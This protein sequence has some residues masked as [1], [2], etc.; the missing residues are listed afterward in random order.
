MKESGVTLEAAND[1]RAGVLRFDLKKFTG[2]NKFYV[3][4]MGFDTDYNESSVSILSNSTV[5]FSNPVHRWYQA[6][7][8]HAGFSGHHHMHFSAE[9]VSYGIIRGYSEVS[10]GDTEGES[11]HKGP[12]AAYFEF[13]LS[14]LSS[15][16]I[17]GAAVGSSFVSRQK[18]EDNMYAELVTSGKDTSALFAL[19]DVVARVSSTWES[20]LSALDISDS[21]EVNVFFANV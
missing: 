3:I 16:A 6:S 9:A 21:T 18:A 13:D 19:D 12:V 15:D 1:N 8:R 5:Q 4:V 2:G 7:G 14:N 20:A 10:P 11:N 17:V